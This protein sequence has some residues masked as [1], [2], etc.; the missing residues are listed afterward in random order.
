MGAK[1]KGYAGSSAACGNARRTI[2]TGDAGGGGAPGGWGGS[3]NAAQGSA[4]V[5]CSIR[6][7][8]R[9]ARRGNRGVSDGFIRPVLS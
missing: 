7:G 6:E 1:R 3:A 9:D 8:R 2:S 4:K 5:P